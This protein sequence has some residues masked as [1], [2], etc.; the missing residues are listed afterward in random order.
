MTILPGQLDLSFA[1]EDDQG[2]HL[3]EMQSGDWETK[4]QALAKVL[5]K[6]PPIAS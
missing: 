6:W 3:Q 4:D 5:P 2:V 1:P